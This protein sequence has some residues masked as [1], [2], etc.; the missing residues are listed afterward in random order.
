MKISNNTVVK[1]RA[2]FALVIIIALFIG[3]QFVDKTMFQIPIYFVNLF[4]IYHFLRL[5]SRTIELSGGCFT[6]RKYHPFTFK[7]FVN[8]YFEL[9]Y[10]RLLGFCI[11]TNFGGQLKLKVISKRQSRF[12]IKIPLSGFTKH[13]KNSLKE[14]LESLVKSSVADDSKQKKIFQNVA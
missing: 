14:S 7:K 11:I 2:Y 6:A 4:A 5:K 10:S 8:P 13:Q 9:P 12:F 1:K 3:V